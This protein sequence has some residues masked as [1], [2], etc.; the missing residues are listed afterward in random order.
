MGGYGKDQGYGGNKGKYSGGGWESGKGAWKG[1][2][3]KGSGNGWGSP[4]WQGKGWEPEGKAWDQWDD[5]AQ[6][7]GW[8]GE[9]SEKTTRIWS[10]YQ[11]PK[12]ILRNTAD[13]DGSAFWKETKTKTSDQTYLAPK[14]M[15]LLMTSDSTHL[16]RR[17]GV[18]ISEVVGTIKA[19]VEVM[20]QID[21]VGMDKLL[22]IFNGATD[23]VHE[24][25]SGSLT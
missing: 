2:G 7:G 5:G 19:G 12:K 3:G 24:A 8:G 21:A 17:P 9:R 11:V 13:V 15:R 10:R 23:T 1:K 22:T 4:Q 14:S 25:M 20:R 18:G 16:I 6:D